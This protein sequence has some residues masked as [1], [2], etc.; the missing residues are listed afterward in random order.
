MYDKIG[1]TPDINIEVV[2]S[3]ADYTYGALLN[4]GKYTNV[5]SYMGI[6]TT[7]STDRVYQMSYSYKRGDNTVQNINYKIPSTMYPLNTY[8]TL[9][10]GKNNKTC[11]TYLDGEKIDEKV[12]EKYAGWLTDKIYIG[13]DLKAADGNG[14]FV[15]GKNYYFKGNIKSIRIYDRPLSQD[16]I[17]INSQIDLERFG[18]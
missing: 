11:Y 15:E 16:E 4:F 1:G 18:S 6:W 3:K 10:Y 5:N 12:A 9:S 17:K 2:S 14:N 13:R 8:K 7:T